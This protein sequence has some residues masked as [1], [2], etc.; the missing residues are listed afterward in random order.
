MVDAATHGVRGAVIVT[1]TDT[2]VGK[3]TVTAAISAAASAAGL[4]VAVV[5]PCQTGTAVETQSDAETVARL[6]APAFV[7]TLE[8]YPEPLAPLTAARIAGQPA[9]GLDA[10]VDTV[11]TLQSLHDLVLIEGAGGVLVPMGSNGWTVIDLAMALLAPAVVVVRAGLGTLNHTALTRLPLARKGIRDF[12]VIGEWPA[13]PAL[14][15]RTNLRDLPVLSGALPERAG[16]MA[17]DDFRRLAPE[18][19]TPD[20]HGHLQPASLTALGL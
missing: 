18:W 3:T 19:L 4:A 15:H 16:A 14:V 2:G 6:A 5:K 8:S 20:L 9:I 7:T 1:G 11:R 12:I 13:E 10:V 17:A